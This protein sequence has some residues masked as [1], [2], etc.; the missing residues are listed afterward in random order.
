MASRIE[1]VLVSIE[2]LEIALVL[3]VVA[4]CCVDFALLL[5]FVASRCR[6]LPRLWVSGGQHGTTNGNK[7]QRCCM[8]FALLLPFVAFVSLEAKPLSRRLRDG[9]SF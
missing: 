4:V 3:P 5:P 9:V 6:L 1:R 2:V 8:D 7:V